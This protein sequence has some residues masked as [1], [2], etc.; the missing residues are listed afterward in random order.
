MGCGRVQQ[1]AE[2]FRRPEVMHP[3]G[4]VRLPLPF[5]LARAI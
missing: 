5:E 3:A 4:V 2:A 1:A